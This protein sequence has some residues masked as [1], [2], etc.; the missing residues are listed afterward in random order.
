MTSI[1][2]HSWPKLLRFSSHHGLRIVSDLLWTQAGVKTAHHH[3]YA[4]PTIF[5]G[6]LI[7]AF[8]RVSLHTH[9]DQIRRLVEWD[10]L[11]PIVVKTNLHVARRQTGE[12]RRREWLHL[13]CADIASI[14]AP[15][16]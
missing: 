4:A 12:R 1:V 16:P 5:A 13:P 7:R 14:S 11:H 8:R 3:R 6:D 2:E 10:R 15:P 9:R